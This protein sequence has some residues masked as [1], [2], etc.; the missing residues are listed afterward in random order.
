MVSCYLDE[1]GTDSD[2]P[3]AVV[4]GLILTPADFFWLDIDW[5]N[6][7]NR[8]NISPPI[9]MRELTPHGK[10]A[11][12][13]ASVRRKLYTDL[14]QIV[15]EHKR[16]SIGAVLA[17]EPYRRIF[18]GVSKMSV[19][20]ACFGLAVMMN[21]ILAPKSGYD[22][23]ISYVLDDGNRYKQDIRDVD[24]GLRCHGVN[25]RKVGFEVDDSNSALQAADMVSWAVRRFL[26]GKLP[27]GFEPLS[28][29]F[30]QHHTEV[31][32]E[33]EWMQS[34]ADKLRD[35]DVPK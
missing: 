32:Y 13:D 30:D 9:H 2:L 19:Y 7:A 11:S 28:D 16:F 3:T 24:A 15:N 6:A 35:S 10:F 17:T 33:E 27:S 8:Y 26:S 34:V 29:L 4:G 22:S 23:S 5:T 21:D 12:V 18:A 20:A 25:I 1:S 14:V 31:P